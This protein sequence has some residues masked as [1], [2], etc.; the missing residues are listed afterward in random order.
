[1]QLFFEKI[2]KNFNWQVQEIIQQ[3]EKILPL[4]EAPLI[5]NVIGKRT[6]ILLY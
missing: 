3:V 2:S 6:P 4:R 5:E 1:M